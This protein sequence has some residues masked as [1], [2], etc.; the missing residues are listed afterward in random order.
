[1]CHGSEEACCSLLRFQL[2]R[3]S[4]ILYTPVPGP[5]SLPASVTVRS[6]PVLPHC[7]LGCFTTGVNAVCAGI[8]LVPSP[9]V[10]TRERKGLC[11]DFTSKGS[12]SLQG[13]RSLFLEA[14]WPLPS[15][16]LSVSLLP[17]SLLH[18]TPSFQGPGQRS[19]ICEWSLFKQI[20]TLWSSHNSF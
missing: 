19:F 3:A 13:S 5:R 16:P 9:P 1:M 7:A 10:T 17:T 12:A 4:F 20:L 2:H 6:P 8:G 11:A 18:T 15:S 14:V